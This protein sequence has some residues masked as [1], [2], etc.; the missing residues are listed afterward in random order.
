[1]LYKKTKVNVCSTDGNTDFF[2]IVAGDLQM[3]TLAP[4]IFIIRHAT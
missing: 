3:D 1:M 4:Y 2:D